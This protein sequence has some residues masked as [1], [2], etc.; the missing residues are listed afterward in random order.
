MVNPNTIIIE[1]NAEHTPLTGRI[2]D[3]LIQ[4]KTGEIL[5]KIVEKVKKI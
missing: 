1:I 3:Y 4:G 2:S 5:P